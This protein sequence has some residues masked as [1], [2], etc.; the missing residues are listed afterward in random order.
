MAATNVKSRF[1]ASA[2]ERLLLLETW[3]RNK[4]DPQGVVAARMVEIAEKDPKRL[5]ELQ[6]NPL[7]A[8]RDLQTDAEREVP[9]YKQDLILYRIAVIVLGS[10]ALIAALG[11]VVLVSGDKTTP[12]V[13]VALG[14]AA[15][16]ALVGLFAPSPSGK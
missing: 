15:V 9:V 3:R 12:E 8:L 11:S 16:G 14:S 13:L 2:D 5:A 7:K 1:S 4:M 10:L 6:A